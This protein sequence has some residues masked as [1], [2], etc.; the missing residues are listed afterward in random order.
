MTELPEFSILSSLSAVFEKNKRG[1]ADLFGVLGAAK[2]LVPIQLAQKM[3]RSL[4]LIT[5]GRIE[6]EALYDDIASYAGEESCVHFPAWEVSPDEIME[7]ADDIVAERMNA[8]ERMADM[9][10]SNTP[11]YAVTSIQAFLQYVTPL[12]TLQKKML[13]LQVGEEHPMEKLIDQLIRRGYKREVMVEQR[14]DFSVRGGILDVFPMSAELPSRLE[15]FD[16]EIESIRAFEPETQRSVTRLEAIRIPPCSEKDSLKEAQRARTLVPFSDCFPKNSLVALVEFLSVRDKAVALTEQWTVSPFFMSWQQAQASLARFPRITL[17][18]MPEQRQEAS[19]RFTMHMSMVEN[20]SG[21]NQE[22]WEQLHAWDLRQYQVRILCV[23]TG[24]ERRFT[25]LLRDHGYRPERDKRISVSLGRI[26]AGFVSH[27][28]K[29]VVLSEREVFG[30][31]YVRRKRRRFEAGAAITEFSDLRAGDYIVHEVHGIGRYLG[32]RRFEGRSSDYLTLNYAGGDTIYVP[33]TQLDQIQK[34]LGGDGAMPKMDRLGGASWAKTKARVRRA[35][36]EMTAEL[37]KLYAARE[38]SEG[39]PFSRD[40]LWQSEFEDAFEYEETP[41]QQRAI[42]EVKRDMESDKPMDRLLC[43]DV[44]YGKT[45]VALRAAFKAVM[46]K[47]QAAL[48]APTTVLVQQHFNTFRERFAAYPITVEVLNRFQSTRQIRSTLERLKSGEV[49]VVVGTHRLLSKDVGFKDLGLVIIDEEQRFG[50]RHKER[51]KAMRTHVDVLTMSATPIPR[52]LHFSMLGI[53]DM[54]VINTA[55]N[56][57]LPIHTC[58]EAW[59]QELIREAVTRE[60][61]RDG[62]VF[63]LHNRVQTIDR[64]AHFLKQLVPHARIGIGHGQMSKNELESVMADFVNHETDVLLCTTIIASGI[65][66]PN[67]NTIIVDRADQFGLSQLYQIRGRVG[68]YKHRA[69]AY[70]LVP[71]DRS[72]TSEA[73]TRLQ[74]LQDFSALGSGY[75]IAMRDME[76]RGTGDL[77]GADQSGHIATVGYETYRDLI[78]EAVAEA[79][80]KTLYKRTL[81]PFDLSVD[82]FI[83]DA[84]IPTGPQKITLYRRIAALTTLEDLQELQEEL[85]D[86]FGPV[87]RPLKRLFQVMEARARAADLGI[88]SMEAGQQTGTLHFDTGKTLAPGIQARLRAM[89]GD[90][91]VFSWKDKP[92]LSLKYEELSQGLEDLSVLLKQLSAMMLEGEDGGEEDSE[93]SFYGY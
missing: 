29:M 57:R 25:E 72:L 39:F 15:Y 27:R 22:F 4:L 5:A 82:A 43:G 1:A 34:Y 74:A 46:D 92:A 55:P 70:M 83:P 41:D 80:G 86:R 36:R 52:T 3:D 91:I 87:P 64:V 88:A 59:D 73:Q 49:D 62:Q 35:V 63:F 93:S 30:R 84:Y 76:I 47:K 32:L 16:D 90:A 24:E 20:Y 19:Q 13:R 44:G 8:L 58:I 9:T 78:A 67:A 75:R 77:L 21:R 71:G 12:H 26:H 48:L 66:I 33:V 7:P 51:L 42:D 53:R 6:A 10:E 18:H 89:Y 38:N 50:V 45:E 61:A 17:S 31:R 81:P 79:Q 56:D 28:D 85:R 54:S 14:G 65:D 23:N 2:A 37:V 69:F 68:R 60:V 11:F 40:T